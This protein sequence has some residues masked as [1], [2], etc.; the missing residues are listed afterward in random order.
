MRMSVSSYLCVWFAASV[1]ACAP[2]LGGDTVPLGSA[3]HY[4]AQIKLNGAPVNDLCHFRFR[5]WTNP[6]F[7]IGFL[8]SVDVDNVE[9]ENGLV[10]LEVDFGSEAFDGNDRW[11]EV[12]IA[13]PGGATLFDYTIL[14]PRQRIAATPYSQFSLETRG[15]QVDGAGNVG[16]GTAAPEDELHI[17]GDR[18]TLKLQGDGNNEIT[19]RVAMRQANGTGVDIYYDGSDG[20]DSL[21]MEGFSAGASTGVHLG[22]DAVSGR[23]G[24][25]TDV[26]EQLLHVFGGDSG[27]SPNS[28]SLFV[29][30][31]D[32]STFINI[33]T[34]ETV[35]SGIL[36]GNP[37]DGNA[38]GGV[39]YNSSNS[40]DGM[41]FRVN[42]NSAKMTI[43]ADGD[44]GVGTISPAADLHVRGSTSLGEMIVTPGTADSSAQI[45]LTENTS[46]SLGAVMKYDGTANQWQVLGKNS[47]GETAP[48]VVVGRDNGR[49]GIGTTSPGGLLHVAGASGNQSV[50]LPSDAIGTGEIVNEAGIASNRLDGAGA[51]DENDDWVVLT[52]SKINCPS[53]GFIFAVGTVSIANSSLG[54]P[55]V[56]VGLTTFADNVPGPAAIYEATIPGVGASV[57]A[58]VQT[59]VEVNS[60]GTKT[61]KLVAQTNGPVV[62]L[63]RRATLLFIP[64]A[65]GEMN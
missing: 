30:E 53:A 39:V 50:I 42:G 12:G 22:I 20:V 60:A 28:N 17:F 5:L 61:V 25:G 13:C 41:Q 37:V 4:Q 2:A 24:I 19:G 48:H 18:P 58:T 46:A 52:T 10:D 14:E 21:L 1:V 64:T 32:T 16:I 45:R 47:N 6:D 33:L 26:P 27:V 11:L 8:G 31:R 57:T 15:I 35:Q 38:A 59:F 51:F 56:E 55:T 34:P 44:V 9:V 36:F 63:S 43:T 29:L 3:F 7:Q 49:V 65:Y 40:P 62:A 23:V 54:S